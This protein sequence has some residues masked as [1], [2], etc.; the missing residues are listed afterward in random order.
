MTVAPFF[1]II[2][3]KC[4]FTIQQKSRLMRYRLLTFASI[5]IL[6]T[7][8]PV[9]G[10]ET[11][12][13][14]I[15]TGKPAPSVVKSGEPFKVAYRAEY[16]DSVLIV[17]EQMQPQNISIDPFEAINLE[18]VALPDQNDEKLGV[19]HM[20]EFI[21]TFMIIKPEKE[22]R[23][24]PEFDF[25]WVE[26][27]A[28]TTET[29]ARDTN[30]LRKI[31]TDE[32]EIG[33]VMSIP[34]KL[35]DSKTPTID[36][37][38]D[39]NF[40]LPKW[41]G[42]EI[43]RSGYWVIGL[44][45]VLFL[46]ILGLFLRNPSAKKHGQKSGKNDPLVAEDEVAPTIQIGKTRKNFLRE[47]KAL[48]NSFRQVDDQFDLEDVQRF[49]KDLHALVSS[50]ILTELSVGPVRVSASQTPKQIY[51]YLLNLSPEQ[52]KKI[53]VRYKVILSLAERA[54]YY[55]EDI[56]SGHSNYFKT[57]TFSWDIKEIISSV[58]DLNFW[59]R[60]KKYLGRSRETGND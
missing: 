34:E 15:K 24:I 14:I 37:R 53:G 16:V 56:Q 29:V 20:R 49:E 59:H 26:K 40:S 23:V 36:V 32:I 33:Y 54:K 27:K 22:T 42:S 7:S 1:I 17:E 44:S 41:K 25:V 46:I 35:P 55:Y 2:C 30:E 50:F 13:I 6:T 8:P 9:L 31:S 28:G 58:E 38:D 3:D 12:P 51:D 19:V 5:L 18:V 52:K 45:S 47:A 4:T 11:S 48:E 43:R 39:M 60:I 21:Y 57:H 10:Q